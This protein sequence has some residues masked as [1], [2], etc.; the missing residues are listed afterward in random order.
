[1]CDFNVNIN[2]NN[3]DIY[4][5]L[6]HEYELDF[7]ENTNLIKSY[8][9]YKSVYFYIKCFMIFLNNHLLFN[10]YLL[11]I[12]LKKIL[13][14]FCINNFIKIYDFNK[15]YNNSIEL[16]IDIF[17]NMHLS[18]DLELQLFNI[19]HNKNKKNISI[20]LTKLLYTYNYTFNLIF[21]NISLLDYDMLI[22]VLN[23]FADKILCLN[24]KLNNIY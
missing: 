7:A 24:I 6:A 18:N 17:I 20:I 10:D 8:L 1:M 16:Y 3:I 15:Y 19:L 23:Y 4:L 5:Y 2:I 13:N 12:L 9:I 14:L 21:L 22:Y 11:Y